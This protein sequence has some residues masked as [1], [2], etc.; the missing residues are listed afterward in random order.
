MISNCTHQEYYK[1]SVILNVI[2][3]VFLGCLVRK[4]TLP[5]T[6]VLLLIRFIRLGAGG[7]MFSYNP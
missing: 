3:L 2:V 7:D 5:Y 1:L 4:K 6:W